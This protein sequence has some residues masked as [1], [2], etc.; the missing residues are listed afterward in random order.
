[1]GAHE[2]AGKDIFYEESMRIPVLI[3]WP[4]KIKPKT[5]RTTMIAFA[6]LYPTLLS[7]MGFYLGWRVSY[8]Y[9]VTSGLL[10]LEYLCNRSL[11]IARLC[12]GH[13]LYKY[14]IASAYNPVTYMDL[15]CLHIY[16]QRQYISTGAFPPSLIVFN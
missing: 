12:V 10:K 13:G 6:D 11:H 5:D 7:I 2:Q 4:E 3:S 9:Y 14:R 15:S 16:S 8:I 1:M